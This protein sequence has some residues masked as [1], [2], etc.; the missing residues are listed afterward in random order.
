LTRAFPDAPVYT[1]VYNAEATFPEFCEVDVRTSALQRVPAFQRDPRLALPFLA[2]TWAGTT[3]TDADVVIASSRGWAHAVAVTPATPKIVYCH[4]PPRWL[5]QRERYVTTRLG[6]AALRL[7]SPYLSSRD[8]AGARTA[9]RYLANSPNVASKIK[10][11]YGID[12]DVLFPPAGLDQDGPQQALTGVEPGYW[13]LVSPGR[14]EAN[15]GATIDAVA[16]S[17]GGRLV[18]VG[19][20]ASPLMAHDPRVHYTGAV[21]DAQLRWAYT[22]ARGLIAISSED[23]GP[24][25]IEATMF[26]TPVVALRAGGCPE[27]VVQGLN[28]IYVDRPDSL[29]LS[30][31]L[32][33]FP[34]FDAELIRR[35]AARFSESEFAE[36]LRAILA[37]TIGDCVPSLRPH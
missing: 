13:L 18:V 3:I 34:A 6:R 9:D 11:A 35:H 2:N 36:R 8:L 27:I 29:E 26:G 33:D 1:S 32:R 17:P 24:T 10:K 14:A 19:R 15:V 4:G 31:A 23:L 37:R 30:R 21:S 5:H 22:N 20:P 28:G 16:K 7:L 12:A 25:P